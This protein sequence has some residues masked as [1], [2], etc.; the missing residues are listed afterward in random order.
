MPAMIQKLAKSSKHSLKVESLMADNPL[1]PIMINHS[2]EMQGVPFMFAGLEYHYGHL[3]RLEKA[4]VLDLQSYMTGRKR[5]STR[6][7][8][9]VHEIRA[10]LN[11]IG[12]LIAC[13]KSTWFSKN[14]VNK[15]QLAILCPAV[16][17]LLPFRNKDAAHRC[18]DQPMGETDSQKE[19]FSSLYCYRAWACKIPKQREGVE[20]VS[21]GHMLPTDLRLTYHAKIPV[22]DRCKI[23]TN[24]S[25]LPVSGIEQPSLDGEIFLS[26]TPIDQH[27]LIIA[28][29]YAAIKAA[30]E[31][32][33][34]P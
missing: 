26:F 12:Q 25:V 8:G 13:M 31:S 14:Y 4:M 16:L 9:H 3:K 18:V 30:F 34:Q 28:E 23:L 6:D 5:K 17:A 10:Y 21:Q 19:S 32:K 33:K 27:P 20:A 24:N 7:F 29:A 1:A 15:S 11:A 2:L 22:K